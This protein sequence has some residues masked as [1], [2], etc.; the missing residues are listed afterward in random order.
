MCDSFHHFS[1]I[2]TEQKTKSEKGFAFSYKRR[3]DPQANELCLCM[4]VIGFIGKAIAYV[5][6]VELCLLEFDLFCWFVK[7][8]SSSFWPKNKAYSVSCFCLELKSVC[9]FLIH[10]S[11]M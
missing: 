6:T 8:V 5:K 9:F 4:C 2:T 1:H 3:A 7:G 11:F 10:L